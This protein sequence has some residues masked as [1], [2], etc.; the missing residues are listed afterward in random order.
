MPWT[1]QNFNIINSY[2]NYDATYRG[3]VYDPSKDNIYVAGYMTLEVGMFNRNLNF[4]GS[5][6]LNM[7]NPYTLILN[8]NKL[9][10]TLL[11][12]IVVVIGNNVITSEIT[13]LCTQIISSLFIDSDGFMAVLC[14]QEN[15]L[16]LY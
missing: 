9:Y 5:I 11:T 2:Y 15:I 4:L 12:S 14:D 8:N 13:T 16:H 7:R 6:R 3:L 1:D 10:V